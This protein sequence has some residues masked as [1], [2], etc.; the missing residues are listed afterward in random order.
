MSALKLFNLSAARL[1]GGRFWLMKSEPNNYSIDDL[2]RDQQALWDGVRNYQARNFMMN[3]MKLKDLALFYHS[4]AK[5]SPG[6]AGLMEISAA[7]VPDP[8]QFDTGSQ[9]YFAKATKQKPVWHCVK[10]QF[11]C[12]LPYLT[13]PELRKQKQLQAM[14]LLQVGQRLS[15]LPI[16]QHEFKRILELC[17]QLKMQ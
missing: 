16:E 17:Q 2:A 4:N 13:L 15:V 7:A 6:V 14:S 5:P 8:T 3:D 1:K 11:L 10:V 9:Y 12:K